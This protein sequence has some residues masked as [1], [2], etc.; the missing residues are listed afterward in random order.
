MGLSIRF[1]QNMAG[2]PAFTKRRYS[3]D[4]SGLGVDGRPRTNGPF[5]FNLGREP[6]VQSTDSGKVQ[7]KTC[8]SGESLH[9]V[10]GSGS[11]ALKV[12]GKGAGAEFP[13]FRGT[14][15]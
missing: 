5:C 9:A 4:A 6:A 2:L 7:Q 13:L 8:S 3:S 12:N 1:G 15:E 14:A 10:W 11:R